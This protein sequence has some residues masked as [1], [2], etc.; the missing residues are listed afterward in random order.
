MKNYYSPLT[1]IEAADTTH[2]SEKGSAQ[3]RELLEYVKPRYKAVVDG[4]ISKEEIAIHYLEVEKEYTEGAKKFATGIV[5]ALGISKGYL[6]KIRNGNR[7]LEEHQGNKPLQQWIGEHPVTCRYLMSKVPHEVVMNKY[8]T[9]A[10][11]KQA[12][13]SQ[14]SR[15]TKED[16]QLNEV[17]E[18]TKT[19]Y[20]LQQEK[21][22][23]MV[24]SDEKPLIRTTGAAACYMS[25]IR[26]DVLAAAA[27]VLYDIKYQD[28]S[29]E[30]ILEIIKKLSQKA[31]EKEPY[32]APSRL[33]EVK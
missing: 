15:E 26:K 19:D 14:V 5:E 25:G 3:I 9:G 23:E 20:Q 22:V 24:E 28:Q 29:L 30:K 27:Q 8:H 21:F 18:T 6:S 13:L 10:H 12:E 31:L 4:E 1:A 2:L 16:E 33:S 17:T 7:F 11:F 32:V